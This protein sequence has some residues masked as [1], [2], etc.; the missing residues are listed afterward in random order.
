LPQLGLEH[1]RAQSSIFMPVALPR[2]LDR[3]RA[4]STPSLTVDRRRA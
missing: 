4:G 1:L 3:G 2:A